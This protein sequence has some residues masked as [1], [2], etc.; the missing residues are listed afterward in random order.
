M[1][2]EFR[3]ATAIRSGVLL[4]CCLVFAPIVCQPADELPSGIGVILEWFS[5]PEPDIVGYYVYA[6]TR[7][8]VYD[9][10]LDA[11][12]AESARVRVDAGITYYF[13]ITARTSDGL[14]S[15][16]SEEIVFTVPIDGIKAALTPM[17]LSFADAAEPVKMEFNARAGYRYLIQV[18]EDLNTWQTLVALTPD[19]DGP[20]A[21]D[22]PETSLHE[23]RFYRVVAE[24]P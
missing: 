15:P 5:S 8:G 1:I 13:A 7:S 19:T 17:A 2:R 21:W 20:I 10:V 12:L 11:G 3:K 18:T 6:G 9:R 22:D 24:T 14:E 16:F 23:F 4:V